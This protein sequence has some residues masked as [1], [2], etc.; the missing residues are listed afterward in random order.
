M[1]SENFEKWF[2]EQL[3]PNIEQGTV[4]VIDNAPYHCRKRENIPT[5]KTRV[6][7][8]KNWLSSKNIPFP[9]K[10]LKRELLALVQSVKFKYNHNQIDLMAE[11]HDM[12]MCRL[13]PYHCELNPI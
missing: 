12:I 2:R 4:I 11:E 7:E 13:P 9:E 5:T 3:L 1:D 6:Q 8:I 10:C